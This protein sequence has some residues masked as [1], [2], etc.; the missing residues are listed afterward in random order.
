MDFAREIRCGRLLLLVVCAVVVPAVTAFA[1]IP[2]RVFDLRVGKGTSLT[3]PVNRSVFVAVPVRSYGRGEVLS[4]YLEQS[5][6]LSQ[7]Q[8]AVHVAVGLAPMMRAEFSAGM[9]QLSVEAGVG[10]NLLSTRVIARRHLGSKLL[11]SPTVSVGVEV[12]WMQGY[13]GMYYMFRHLSNASMFVDNDGINY[14]Y[15]IFSFRFSRI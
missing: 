14:Q 9:L 3:D 13:V 12:P 1:Q 8:G 11:F 4:L 7:E 15:I 2:H 10:L 5:L 6:L